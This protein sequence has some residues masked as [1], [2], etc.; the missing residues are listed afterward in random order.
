M[1]KGE[2]ELKG[3]SSPERKIIFVIIYLT[4]GSILGNRGER[5]NTTTTATYYSRCLDADLRTMEAATC[6]HS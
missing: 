3:A 2:D 5:F 4:G 1:K 6:D